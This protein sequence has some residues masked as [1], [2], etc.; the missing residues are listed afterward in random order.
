MF[1]RKS[2]DHIKTNKW[3]FLFFIVLFVVGIITFKDY[4]ISAD[5]EMQRRHTFVNYYEYL[6]IFPIEKSTIQNS[7]YYYTIQFYDFCVNNYPYKYYGVGI[8]L[9]ITILEHFNGFRFSSN[10]IYNIRHF[11]TFLIYFIAMIYFYLILNRYILKNKNFSLIGTIFLVISPKIYG[12]AFYNIKD[13]M[14]MS[15]CIIN[16]YYCM[17]FLEDSKLKN[18]IKLSIITAFTMNSRIIG[19]LIIFLCFIF[20]LLLNKKNV[21]NILFKLLLVLI[22]TYIFYFIMTPPMWYNPIKYPFEVIKFFNHYVDPIPKSGFVSL[23]FGKYVPANN[24]PWH[25]LPVF[26]IISTPIL[27]ILLFLI[28]F[29]DNIKKLLNKKIISSINL[30]F[31]NTILFI[32]L[33]LCIIVKPTLYGGWRHAYFIYPMIIVNSIIG[34]RWL[35]KKINKFRILINIIII[36]NIL[37]VINWMIKNHPYQSNY[38][39]MPFRKYAIE[40]FDNNYWKLAN[41][42]ALEY[43]AKIDNRDTISVKSEYNGASLNKLNYIDKKRI[44][45]DYIIIKDW[46]ELDDYDY[47]IDTNIHGN[48]K[49][50][51]DYREIKVKKMD[52]IRLYTIYK[53]K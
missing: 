49:L 39:S 23:Y 2:L 16:C 4:G 37:I 15:L 29:I 13:L 17:R 3:V 38:F 48:D 7:E 46:N 45:V 35:L 24:L 5:E 11:Y 43:I 10:T 6:K 27:Y 53:H 30:L 52:G 25:Y 28:G 47:F 50:K 20:S 12:D 44:I 36:L 34:L 21:K 33:L 8:Q 32:V 42:D 51:E 26:I 18:I 22:F 40:N 9:P 14:F 41:S 31:I 19:A 1:W